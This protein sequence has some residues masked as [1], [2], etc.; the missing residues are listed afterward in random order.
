MLIARR[1]QNGQQSQ[2]E[3]E[4]ER[5]RSIFTTIFTTLRAVNRYVRSFLTA[6]EICKTHCTETGLRPEDLRL[7]LHETQNPS[8]H[9]GT[10]SLPTV[11]E[12]AILLPT[13]TP[14]NAHRSIIM[15][16]RDPQ[17]GPSQLQI[18]QDY[19]RSWDPLMYPLFFPF[20]TSGW[21]SDLTSLQPDDSPG[22]ASV[23]L[24]QYFRYHVMER[25]NVFNPLH[26]GRRLF[27]QYVVDKF[28]A[29]ESARL[30]Y[31]RQH[32]ADLRLDSYQRL[33]DA[34]QRGN[35]ADSGRVTVLPATFTCSERWYDKQYKNAMALVR[36]F[37]KPTFFITYTLDTNCQEI[38]DKLKQ[39]QTP[40]DRPDLLVRVFRAKMKQLMHEIKV[41]KI[42]GGEC[43][44]HSLAIEFQ[45]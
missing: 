11:D 17:N 25:P 43:P 6:R 14:E 9:V 37:G 19:H 15:N 45:K 41:G 1:R 44:A 40:Y 7:Q 24:S 28:A 34:F 39:G 20:G 16:V 4:Q 36:K 8:G 33:N 32:Q 23:M 31:L 18:V 30:R 12:V 29:V 5:E 21:H 42:F 10:Y 26:H 22:T 3:I 13:D 38:R 2:S 27:Q 35:V